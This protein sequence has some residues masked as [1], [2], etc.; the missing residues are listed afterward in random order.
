MEHDVHGVWRGFGSSRVQR[1]LTRL[2]GKR[3]KAPF[4][5]VRIA[6]TFESRVDLVNSGGLFAVP[7]ALLVPGS[8]VRC[9]SRYWSQYNS[10][11]LVEAE[12]VPVG[13]VR[14][15]YRLGCKGAGGL[16]AR[17][18]LRPDWFSIG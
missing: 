7:A 14:V 12:E 9:P 17:S 3:E 1:S 8:P 13:Y 6:R 15:T 16:M 11:G 2:T 5:S 10:A 18:H 4:A